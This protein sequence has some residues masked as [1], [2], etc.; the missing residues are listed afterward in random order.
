MTWESQLTG[1]YFDHN[2]I[3]G[4]RL[5]KICQIFHH[6]HSLNELSFSHNPITDVGLYYLLR[7]SLNPLRRAYS[8]LPV[9]YLIEAAQCSTLEMDK[10]N[11]EMIEDIDTDEESETKVILHY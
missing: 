10:A 9:P 4:H 3:D 6:C 2:H 11:L 1:L 7:G 5:K 8:T